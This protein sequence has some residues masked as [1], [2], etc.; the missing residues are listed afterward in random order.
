MRAWIRSVPVL[1]VVVIAAGL[2]GCQAP[3][4]NL[5][6]PLVY[7][8]GSAVSGRAALTTSPGLKLYVEVVDERPDK[9]KIGENVEEEQPRPIYGGAE[10]ADFVRGAVS[11]EL[12]G[13]GLAVVGDKS[14]ANRT[15]TL[16]L[17][18]FY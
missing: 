15:L 1:G 11:R 12:P 14:I 4:K 13:V 7:R 3:K 17:I 2:F 10:P 16:H 6:V 8:P 18:R 9:S 5:T